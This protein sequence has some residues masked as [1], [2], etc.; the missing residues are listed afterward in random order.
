MLKR[1]AIEDDETIYIWVDVVDKLVFIV[2][3]ISDEF[4]FGFSYS[5]DNGT[6]YI[7]FAN[8]IAILRAV[9]EVSSPWFPQSE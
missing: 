1:S 4:D 3:R 8:C 5:T 2:I 9:G 6:G 7:A